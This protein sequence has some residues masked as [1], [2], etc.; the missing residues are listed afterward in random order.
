MFKQP[1][2][3][4]GR[5]FGNNA[6]GVTRTCPYAKV[7]DSTTWAVHFAAAPRPI[8]AATADPFS[9]F[10]ASSLRDVRNDCIRAL[11]IFKNFRMWN[12]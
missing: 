3:E 11:R 5:P 12:L 1:T 8:R 6:N 7:A 4:I 2:T 9:P 10:A